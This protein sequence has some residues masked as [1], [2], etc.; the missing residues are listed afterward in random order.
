[1]IECIRGT[2]S[3]AKDKPFP[4]PVAPKESSRASPILGD[5]SYDRHFRQSGSDWLF[6]F[7]ANIQ[8]G[9]AMGLFCI[10]FRSFACEGPVPIYAEDFVDF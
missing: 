2:A 5:V 10:Y 8:D 7:E 1:M 4:P 9:G 6:G 3:D